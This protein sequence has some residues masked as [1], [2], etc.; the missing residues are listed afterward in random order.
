MTA[1]A[2]QGDTGLAL[3]RKLY[4]RANMIDDHL[5]IQN[6]FNEVE[7]WDK[8]KMGYKSSKCSLL[9]LQRL[10]KLQVTDK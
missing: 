3:P 7:C 10:H 4:W 1:K 6:H 2:V 9:A 5:E 8:A